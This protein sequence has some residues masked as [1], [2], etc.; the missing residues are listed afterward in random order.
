MARSVLVVILI[1][2]LG[3]FIFYSI[4]NPGF[5]RNLLDRNEKQEE[6]EA[7][8]TLEASRVPDNGNY[9]E[10]DDAAAAGQSSYPAGTEADSLGGNS[11]SIDTET[12]GSLSPWQKIL[13]FFK[14]I[15]QPQD[16]AEVYPSRININIYFAATGE[17][18]KLVAEER[19]IIAGSP[20][21]ALNNAVAELLKGPAKSYHFPVIPA[22]TRLKGS[23]VSEGV[24]EIDL[25][26]EFLENSLDTRILDEYI[27]YSIVNTITG[28]QGIDG[29]VFLIE[30]KRIKMYGDIDMSIPLIRNPDLIDD[31]TATTGGEVDLQGEEDKSA[32]AE[33]IFSSTEEDPAGDEG[34][35]QDDEGDPGGGQENTQ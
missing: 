4:D 2:T 9:G 1:F 35:P 8:A 23:K 28:I 30:G 16:Q 25:S 22:G 29:A 3:F 17:G 15:N 12:G 32:D 27:I 26:G 5:L 21:N 34:I 14:R 7:V 31:G 33:D 11:G 20:G 10:E 13:A 18:K 6:D 19:S 24:A